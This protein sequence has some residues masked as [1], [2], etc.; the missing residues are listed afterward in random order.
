MII[1]KNFGEDA[2]YVCMAI[3]HDLWF[4]SNGAFIDD[5]GFAID[6]CFYIFSCARKAVMFHTNSNPL[7]F[8]E[9]ESLPIL[10]SFD[11]RVLQEFHDHIASHYRWRLRRT[12]EFA[13]SNK[14]KDNLAYKLDAWKLYLRYEVTDIMF[15]NLD[16]AEH[17]ARAVLFQNTKDGYESEDRSVQYL[18]PIHKRRSY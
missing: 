13:F 6:S 5:N 15:N 12:E 7:F 18:V 1:G 17:I 9:R 14:E 16:V 11:H 2:D 8:P 3:Q 4:K 10:E